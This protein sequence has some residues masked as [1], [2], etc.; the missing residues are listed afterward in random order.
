M[1]VAPK[2]I[3]ANHIADYF[4]SLSNESGNLISNLKLQKLLYYAQAWHLAYYK[5]R[6]FE[7]SF[8]AWVHGPVLPEIY[9]K[10]KHFSWK[11]IERNDLDKSYIDHFASTIVMPE[12]YE[13]LQEVVNEYFGLTSFELEKMTHQESPCEIARQGLSNDEPSNKVIEDQWLIDYYSKYVNVEE[14]I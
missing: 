8:Q 4:I 5:T 13:L 3:T 6:L 11:P 14:E 12:Q 7:G 9:D 1:T 2:N 10:Y